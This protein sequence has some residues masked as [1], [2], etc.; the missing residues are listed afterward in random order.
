MENNP[1]LSILKF[2]SQWY[3]R[4]NGEPKLSNAKYYQPLI[5][6]WSSDS[7]GVAVEAVASSEIASNIS[8][9]SYVNTKIVLFV[10]K[11]LLSEL[12]PLLM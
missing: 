3:F 5:Q 9:H 2:S 11:K 6:K 12:T 8:S 10:Y 1:L 4:W 7:Y